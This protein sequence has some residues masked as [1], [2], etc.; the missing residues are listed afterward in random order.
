MEA[1][2]KALS[3]LSIREY[4]AKELREK[5]FSRGYD[6]KD[7]DDTLERLIS[8]GS[9][10]EERFAKSYIRSRFNRTPEGKR[11]LAMRMR[12]KGCDK[13][14][15][16]DAISAFWEEGE[17]LE[18]LYE[19]YASIIKKKGAA[20]AEADLY[21]RGFTFTEIGEVKELYREREEDDDA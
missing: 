2:D 8:E 21:K 12:E 4:T 17:Y 7:V 16:D 19:Y 18:P 9:L 6:S 10:S 11:V 20:K 5:L 3:L 1:Y 13:G 15:I 14:A